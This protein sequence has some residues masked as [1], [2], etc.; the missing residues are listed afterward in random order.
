MSEY[1]GETLRL[2]IESKMNGKK[3]IHNGNMG[4]YEDFTPLNKDDV[5]G[6]EET[7]KGL[8]TYLVTHT[9]HKIYLHTFG[10]EIQ[11]KDNAMNMGQ[12]FVGYDESIDSKL[13]LCYCKD[14]FLAIE[15]MGLM[16][17][18]T[19]DKPKTKVVKG[20]QQGEEVNVSPTEEEPVEGT[21]EGLEANTEEYQ[22]YGWG[23]YGRDSILSMLYNRLDKLCAR[24]ESQPEVTAKNVQEFR[25]EVKKVIKENEE[26]LTKGMPLT[27][28]APVYEMITE[29]LEQLSKV[30]PYLRVHKEKSNL[31]METSNGEISLNVY[32][33]ELGKDHYGGVGNVMVTVNTPVHKGFRKV[34]DFLSSNVSY[35]RITAGNEAFKEV[36]PEVK[37]ETKPTV[38]KES[39][40]SDKKEVAKVDIHNGLS[41]QYFNIYLTKAGDWGKKDDKYTELKEIIEG[42]IRENDIEGVTLRGLDDTEV[43]IDWV[44]DNETYTMALTEKATKVKELAMK[45]DM[46]IAY[47]TEFPN[48]IGVLIKD[49]LNKVFEKLDN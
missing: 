34:I 27:K 35:A 43:F 25:E 11:A 7:V 46:A 23:E 8:Y 30:Y 9:K 4:V 45:Y 5:K 26:I 29:F 22:D 6:L 13:R 10:V 2:T 20:Q 15:I 37:K 41:E 48:I 12:S 39:H 24:L 21:P 3:V 31:L 16:Q 19:G 47:D 33:R 18:F 38:N 44:I 32:D 40:K 28:G 42:L 36:E 17:D 14:T 49:K 1:S